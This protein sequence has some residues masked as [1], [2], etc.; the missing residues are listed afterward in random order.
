METFARQLATFVILMATFIYASL[1]EH[2]TANCRNLAPQME[3]FYLTYS[4][5]REPWKL[6]GGCLASLKLPI[7]ARHGTAVFF[8]GSK[9][10]SVDVLLLM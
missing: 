9:E 5:R 6:V 2:I 3:C 8:N 10:K 4:S 7:G 1:I